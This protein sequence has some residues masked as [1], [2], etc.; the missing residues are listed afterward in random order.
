MRKKVVLILVVLAAAAAVLLLVRHYR[1]ARDDGAMLL[2]GNVEVTEVN[3]GFK[4][5]GRVIERLVDE[6]YKV[7]TGDVI[8]RLDNVELTTMVTQSRASLRE[9][10]TRLAELEAGSRFQEKEQAR[11]NVAAQDAELQKVKKDLERARVLYKN[12]AIS[13]SQFDVAVSVYD[14]RKA[15]YE[16]ALEAQSLTK[17]GPRKED[18]KMAEHRVELAK[19]ALDT[20]ETRLGDTVI[21]APV[22]G[23]VLRKNVEAGE[24]IAAGTPI[25]TIGDLAKPWIK[26]YVKEDKLPFV[27]LGQKARVSV[28]A[29]KNKFY[30][31]EVSYISSEA[32][33]TP[34]TVQTPEER[35]KLVFGVK[36]RVNNDHGELK[37][38]M[39]AD[40]RIAVTP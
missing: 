38:G 13:A 11:A 26:V 40:V 34:K 18:I 29:Y 10:A 16:N 3:V 27:K 22:D 33:F 39:P 8:A 24:T 2:S 35:V 9:A 32:E 1:G 12:G 4:I 15:L 6:G 5:P 20:S 36:V 23:V 25:V 21:Y 14:G 37:P 28:D 31:G 17:E 7:H 30:D 19:G